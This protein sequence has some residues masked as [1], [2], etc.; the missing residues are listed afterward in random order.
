LSARSIYAVE[1]VLEE[2][3][4]NV[5]AYGFPQG[6]AGRVI[7]GVRLLDDVVEL[8]LD[9]DGIAF[10]PLGRQPAPRPASIE[11]ATPGGLGLQLIQ[12]FS[13]TVTYRRTNGRNVLT[14]TVARTS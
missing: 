2:A 13:R 6:Q 5:I 4:T 3:L 12:R 1:L 7:L 8:C 14:V 10:D 11:E 9:D